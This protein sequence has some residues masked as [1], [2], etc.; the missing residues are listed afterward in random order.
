MQNCHYDVH[1]SALNP[2]AAGSPVGFRAKGVCDH[3]AAINWDAAEQEDAVV[4]VG[5][6]EEA[7]DAARERAKS[8]AVVLVVVVD[9]EGYGEDKQQIRDGQAQ[10][11]DTKHV[12]ATHL[13][14]N[15]DQ[16]QEIEDQAKYER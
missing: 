10:Q 15:R 8:P 4:H 12:L 3:N 5:V 16:S 7:G 13:L 1:H 6:V 2:G 11:K 9:P 14:E